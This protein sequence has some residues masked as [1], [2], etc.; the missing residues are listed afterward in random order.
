MTSSRLAENALQSGLQA[1]TLLGRALTLIVSG[2]GHGDVDTFPKLNSSPT[3]THTVMTGSN[4]QMTKL[5]TVASGLDGSSSTTTSITYTC[6]EVSPYSAI[7]FYQYTPKGT[8][9]GE[10]TWTTRFTITD[11]NGK[12]VAEPQKTQPDGKAIPWGTGKLVDSVTP[13]TGSS[14]SS[15]ASSSSGSSNSTTSGTSTSAS[16]QQQQ[17]SSSA[18]V[19]ASP[20]TQ[21]SA[22][23]ASTAS[24]S[25]S[26]SSSQQQNSSSNASTNKSNSTTSGALT[27]N[28][29]SASSLVGAVVAVFA[30]ASLLV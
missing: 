27:L 5:A 28:V 3:P 20:S 13:A 29:A 30:A 11:A 26:S 17:Q 4:T 14:S 15:N 21:S 23:T 12:S 7:Y 22:S 2:S 25:S 19:A 1:L 6:P 24:T 10:P 8:S 16:Q 18:S 9:D